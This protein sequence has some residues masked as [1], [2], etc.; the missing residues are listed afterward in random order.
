MSQDDEQFRT[1]D[2]IVDRWFGSDV[3]KN[4]CNH[5]DQGDADSI[6]M[7]EHICLQLSSLIFHAS[8]RSAHSRIEY[9]LD[10]FTKL[11]DEFDIPSKW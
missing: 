5:A 3:W 2:E 10:Y 8:N 11:C 9:E 7:M 1:G 6:E 4:I